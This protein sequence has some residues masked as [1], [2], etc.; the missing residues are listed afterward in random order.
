M[1]VES[2]IAKALSRS[3][4]NASA[5]ITIFEDYVDEDYGES[6]FDLIE[7]VFS[8]DKLP[9]SGSNDDS[10]IASSCIVGRCLDSSC[11]SNAQCPQ[12]HNSSSSS[13]VE[14]CHLKYDVPLL[15]FESASKS[16][17]LDRSSNLASDFA[18]VPHD[19]LKLLNK[20]SCNE[21]LTKVSIL[22]SEIML[23]HLSFE[24][25][26]LHYEDSILELE[27]SLEDS[28]RSMNNKELGSTSLEPSR[29]HKDDEFASLIQPKK[30][31][32]ENSAIAPRCLSPSFTCPTSISCNLNKSSA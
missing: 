2:S 30:L 19:V 26:S 27:K 10:P 7:E 28:L 22:K 3:S 18:S 13:S 31:F 8:S 21:L 11:S 23:Q 15:K 1:V 12:A 29:M 6:S 20:A 25:P 9:S 17:E 4:S 32:Q 5:S 16:S 24:T 14:S